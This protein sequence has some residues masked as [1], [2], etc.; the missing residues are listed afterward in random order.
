MEWL[1]NG[2]GISFWEIKMFG[3]RYS[4]WLHNTVNFLQ[5]TEVYTLKWLKCS[6]LCYLYLPEFKIKH[7]KIRSQ[8]SVS[9][10]LFKVYLISYRISRV[11]E[12]TSW[13]HK[14][15]SLYSCATYEPFLCLFV[16]G[17]VEVI[18]IITA[19]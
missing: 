1:L 19:L 9:I 2:N 6:S 13:L 8:N 12:F 17:K 4:W 14:I 11:S 15:L 5:S 10:Y 16:C 3:T 7:T 18:I